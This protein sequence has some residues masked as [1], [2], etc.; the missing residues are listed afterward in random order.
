MF[1]QNQKMQVE[2]IRQGKKT[3]EKIRGLF[4]LRVTANTYTFHI[5]SIHAPMGRHVHAFSRSRNR[6]AISIHAPKGGNYLC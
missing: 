5:F 4:C 2:K 3:P 6:L 1:R